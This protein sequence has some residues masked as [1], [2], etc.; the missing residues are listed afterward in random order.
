[1]TRLR[2]KTTTLA[3]LLSRGHVSVVSRKLRRWLFSDTSYWGLIRDLTQPFD[4]RPAKIPLALHPIE[5]GDIAKLLNLDEGAITGQEA[6][7]RWDRLHLLNA[8]FGTC[9]AAVAGHNN[10]CYM[11]WL[12]GPAQNDRIQ[13]YF[14]GVFP[15]L[16]PDEVLL[17]KAFAHESYRGL[18][19]MPFAMSQIAEERAGRSHSLTV[20]ASRHSRDARGLALSLACCGSIGG[21][22]F[23]RRSSSRICP[24]GQPI[25]RAS[26]AQREICSHRWVAT[27]G[28]IRKSK[29]AHRSES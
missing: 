14:R 16:T 15:L 6:Y 1:V 12:F 20:P 25:L 8:D 24:L 2:E 13:A 22:C 4:T 29:L 23:V 28:W 27:T 18:G 5:D 19:I 26:R 17:E 9:Y 3:Y 7:E 10:P 11:Q 21:G